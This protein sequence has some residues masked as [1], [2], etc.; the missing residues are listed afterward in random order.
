MANAFIIIVI[1]IFL[2]FGVKDFLKKMASGCCGGS[3]DLPERK[4]VRDRNRLHY[5]HE[6]VMRI[7]GMTCR[8]CAIR[9]ENALNE[10]EGIWAKVNL[11]EGSA[12][13]L[14][15]ERISEERLAAPVCRAGYSVRRIRWKR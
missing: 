8:N 7:Q 5:P 3:G 15:K 6:A 10:E 14:L 11:M 1:V 9:V 4:P 12:D 13:I 2:L